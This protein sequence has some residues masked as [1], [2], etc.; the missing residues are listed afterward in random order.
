MAQKDGDIKCLINEKDNLKQEI[1]YL[2]ALENKF[3]VLCEENEE[4]KLISEKY[5][6]LRREYEKNPKKI[7]WRKRQFKRK[8]KNNEHRIKRDKK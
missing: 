1:L 4:L 7:F 5:D 8:N 6:N 3:N 2:K